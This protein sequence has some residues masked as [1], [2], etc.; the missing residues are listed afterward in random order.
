[1]PKDYQEVERIVEELKDRLNL[2][3]ETVRGIDEVALV[4]NVLIT[5]GNSR[6]LEA[7]EKVE[8]GVPTKSEP[9]GAWESG[10]VMG[11]NDCRQAI[12]DHIE[13]VKKELK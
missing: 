10:E 8:K 6:A 3:E 2:R 11:W 1:M 4:H 12:L 7:V 5:Y 13:R 9:R